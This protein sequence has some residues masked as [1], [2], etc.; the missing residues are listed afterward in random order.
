M[1]INNINFK[2][3][4]VLLFTFLITFWACKDE[5]MDYPR[6]RLFMPVLNEDLYSVDNTIVVN[7]GKMKEA[8][9]YKIEVSRDS[10][11]TIDYTFQSDTNYFIL[12]K[13]TL[14]EDLLW[15]TV[16]QVRATAFADLSEFNSL[17]SLLGSVRTQKFPS[18]MGT[19]TFFDVLDTRARVFWTPSGAPITKIKVFA[20]DDLRLQ[21]PLSEFDVTDEDRLATEKIVGGL[22]GSSIYQIAIYSDDAVR[23]WEVYNTRPPL[24]SG[25]NVV[26]LTGID[27]GTVNLAA[28]LPD[29]VDGSII[30]LE[31]GKT[32]LAG[33]YAFDK[34]VEFMSGYSFTPALPVINCVSNFNLADGSNVGYVKFKDIELTS[35]GVDGFNGRYVINTNVSANIGEIKFESCL[36]HSLRGVLRM[37][38]AG[39]GVLDKYTIESCMI[40]SIKDYGILTVDRNDWICNNISI[41]NSTIS[42][43]IMLFTSR[44][45]STSFIIDAC[46]I[47][48]APEKGRQ[49]FRWREAGQDN[50]LEGITISN[51]I[52]GHGW[53]TSGDTDYLVDGYDGMGTT[54]WIITNTYAT[55][56]FGYVV[57]K[58]QIPGFPSFNYSGTVHDLWTDP[59]NSI[60]NIKDL[61]FAG[62]SNAGDPR[63]RIGI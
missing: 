59:D 34:S 35:P 41:K 9:N 23:G 26:D 62:K 24:V 2:A 25:D 48:E 10:F 32:Y 40:D 60:F 61:G 54:N 39:P 46:T 31:G 18:N 11:I 7:M 43:A 19:P 29:V 36:I 47:N 16:Y 51:T 1:N 63:W 13:E 20:G 57:G 3:G 8:E 15:Y 42:K 33:G 21:N 27:T 14:G 4:L 55:G 44:N 37:K 17:P 38:D 12:N 50:V 30:L 53:N 5:E 56:D 58:E 28:V 45:N 22:T 49:M 6:T 52:W